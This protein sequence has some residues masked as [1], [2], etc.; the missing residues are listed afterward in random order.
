[1]ISH[2]IWVLYSYKHCVLRLLIVW[3]L[4]DR[5]DHVCRDIAYTVYLLDDVLVV[6]VYI[7]HCT[8]IVGLFIIARGLRWVSVPRG[9]K[10]LLTTHFFL[11][12]MFLGLETPK[13]NLEGGDFLRGWG[14]G[15]FYWLHFFFFKFG[16]G[17][18]LGH[19]TPPPGGRAG[20]ENDTLLPLTM[21]G[22]NSEPPW[23]SKVIVRKP[24]RRKK[25][26]KYK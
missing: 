7:S 4:I 24:W 23:Q 18:I 17:G 14:G 3:T 1:M 12:K 15:S 19:L 10:F 16:G 2:H 13:K 20:S 8:V 25:I 6:I 26:N 9:W 22:K 21:T 5:L 11:Q